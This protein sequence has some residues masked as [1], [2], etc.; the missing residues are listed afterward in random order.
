VRFSLVTLFV[1][2]P[3]TVADWYREH[4]GLSVVDR[5][6]RFVRLADDGGAPCLA[7]HAGAPVQRPEHVQLH[8]EVADVDAEHRRLTAEGAT[9][10][11]PPADKPWGWR[12]AAFADPAGHTV[13]VVKPL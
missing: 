4:L 5:T 13:E 8:F 7:L 3:F 11:S 9:S 2:D 1:E 6:D 12:V 10:V